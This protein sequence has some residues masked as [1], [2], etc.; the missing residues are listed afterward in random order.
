MSFVYTTLLTEH[1]NNKDSYSEVNNEYRRIHNP[2]AKQKEQF[3]R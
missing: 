3:L 1:T 2:A